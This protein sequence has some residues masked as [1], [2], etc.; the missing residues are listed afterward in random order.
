MGAGGSMV[1]V[2]DHYHPGEHQYCLTHKQEIID[3]DDL[4]K[5]YVT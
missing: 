1:V 2:Q 3:K 4:L 5:E